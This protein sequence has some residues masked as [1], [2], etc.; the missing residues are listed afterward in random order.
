MYENYIDTVKIIWKDYRWELFA[1]L[2][3]LILILFYYF[4][5]QDEYKGLQLKYRIE[6]SPS[7]LKRNKY[8]YETECK[9]IV[10]NIFGL[11]FIKVRPDFLK[12]PKTGRNLELDLYN[13]NLKI[14]IEYQ[15]AQHRTFTPFFHK[16]QQDFL[17]QLEKD[18]YKVERCKAEGIN[19]ICIPDHIPFDELEGY[20]K[21]QLSKGD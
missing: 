16:T 9:R 10:E 8:K 19:L 15:G 7:P 3:I 20:I 11:P 12:N 4:S 6:K 2:S 17:Y 21:N 14:A 1:V 18:K 13:K 5:N